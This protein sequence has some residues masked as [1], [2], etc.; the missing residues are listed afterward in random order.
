MTR[1]DIIRMAM[2]AGMSVIGAT[3]GLYD[4][5]IA[6]GKIESLVRFAKQAHEAGAKAE[7]EEC[8]K[9]CDDSLQAIEAAA[10]NLAKV[11]GRHNSELAMNQ[12]LEALK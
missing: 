12:L 3:S 5:S 10:Q 1:D 6:S 9:V 4:N 7:R 2:D 11:R 8:A